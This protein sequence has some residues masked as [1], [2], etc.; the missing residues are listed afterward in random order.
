MEERRECIDNLWKVE[1]Y[2][3]FCKERPDPRTIV[4]LATM[5]LSGEEVADGP[6]AGGEWPKERT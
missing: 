4:K 5:T 6:I 1:F 2:H 3:T